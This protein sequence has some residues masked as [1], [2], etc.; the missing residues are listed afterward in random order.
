MLYP[1]RE[2][3]KNANS[4]PKSAERH[5]WAS[6]RAQ[7]LLREVRGI[8][9]KVFK[10]NSSCVRYSMP[11]QK[12]TSSR[13]H[14]NGLNGFRNTKVLCA[15]FRRASP[16]LIICWLVFKNPTSFFLPPVL[17]WEKPRSLWISQD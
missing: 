8:M 12:K 15:V 14:G 4:L 16:S 6:S 3:L 9:Q 1:F 11:R 5:F 2:N 13:M 10:Q 7:P 17:Q